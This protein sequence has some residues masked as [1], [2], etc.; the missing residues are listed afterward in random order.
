MRPHRRQPTRLPCPWGS[1]DKNTGLGYH[2]LLQRI[3]RREY[4]TVRTHTKETT[5][6]QDP[7]SP[8]HQQHRVQDASSEQQTKQKYKLN[9]QQRGFTISLSLTH[10]RKNKKSAQ[11][12]LYT[13]LTQTT[14]PAFSSVQFSCSVM[15]NSLWPYELQ[16]ARPLCPSPTPG[17]RYNP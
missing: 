16:H 12:S 2:F 7:V 8:N 4:Q 9:H 6:T 3:N 11:I 17:V 10:Q 5:W 1:L 13:K 14:G 15:S